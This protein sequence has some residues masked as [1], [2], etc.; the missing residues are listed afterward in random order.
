MRFDRS[1]AYERLTSE[2][3]I[4]KRDFAGKPSCGPSAKHQAVAF[5]AQFETISGI[6]F[7]PTDARS[8]AE[9]ASEDF[10]IEASKLN[11]LYSAVMRSFANRIRQP[12]F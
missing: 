5:R 1:D 9:A 3:A 10:E 6:D 4:Q 8:M 12:M 7:F 11:Y 2:V